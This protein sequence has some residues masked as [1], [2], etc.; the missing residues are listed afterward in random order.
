M[1]FHAGFT[2]WIA[3]DRDNESLRVQRPRTVKLSPGFSKKRV[4]DFVIVKK[5]PE[6]R[7]MPD[8]HAQVHVAY[9]R[10]H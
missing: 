10:V 4:N 1:R 9:K 7:R 2:G 8:E 5:W 6:A 3:V